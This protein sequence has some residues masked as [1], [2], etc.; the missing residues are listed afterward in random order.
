MIAFV[1]KHDHLLT[2]RRIVNGRKITIDQKI[3]SLPFARAS[4]VMADEQ[5]GT[6]MSTLVSL[7]RPDMVPLYSMMDASS[8]IALETKLLNESKI[9]KTGRFSTTNS[10]ETS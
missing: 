1:P 10:A 7:N 2:R 9:Q 3:S 4:T 5:T 8:V 6:T